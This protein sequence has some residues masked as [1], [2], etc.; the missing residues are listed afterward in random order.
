MIALS[1]DH[2]ESKKSSSVS[3]GFSLLDDNNDLSRYFREIQKYPMLGADEEYELAQEW[4]K[5]QDK[6]AAEKLVNSHLRLVTK[7]AA[8]YRGYGLPLGDLI[9]EGNLGILHALKKFDPNKGFR[10]STYAMWWIKAFM[11]D[12][13]LKSWSLV[14]MGTTVAQKK[15]FF[16][17]KKLKKQLQGEN[18]WSSLSNE[19]IDSIAEKLGVSEQEVRD[20]E[21]R[22]SGGDS[23]LNATVSQGGEGNETEWQDWVE[24]DRPDQEEIFMA[25]DQKKREAAL[26][27]EGF[28]YL[29]PREMAVIKARRLKEPPETLEEISHTLNLSKERVRQIE[30]AA[31]SKLRDHM[32]RIA[33]EHGWVGQGSLWN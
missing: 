29:T 10:F 5:N 23:S 11:Q 27:Q 15:L 9:A 3:H 33:E 7:I 22:L 14:K 32:R 17:L 26:L 21:K 13:I 12:Y 2:I 30:G 1:E 6:V 24:S 4:V 18:E 31:F 8:G 25:T 20:M 28:E 16:N 19:T